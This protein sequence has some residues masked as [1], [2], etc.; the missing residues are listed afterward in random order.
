MLLISI[1]SFPLAFHVRQAYSFNS[2]GYINS[3]H[4]CLGRMGC[5]NKVPSTGRLIKNYKFFLT[6][7]KV[8]HLRS[9]CLNSQVLVRPLFCVA[10]QGR[11]R[12]RELT[13]RPFIRALIPSMK[14]PASWPHYFPKPPPPNTITFQH[15]NFGGIRNIQSTTV[16]H[17]ANLLKYPLPMKLCKSLF[18]KCSLNQLSQPSD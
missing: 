2:L 12:V 3:F 14:V 8:G 4:L 6:V 5:Y 9:G 18:L 10:S 7:P 16:S 13:G 11:N 1:L 17:L 15:T